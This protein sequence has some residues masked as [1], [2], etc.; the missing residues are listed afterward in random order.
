M[1][2]EH[3]PDATDDRQ[4]VQFV[5]PRIVDDPLSVH[6]MEAIAAWTAAQSYNC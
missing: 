4:V 2:A 6:V 3:P 1:T 5:L